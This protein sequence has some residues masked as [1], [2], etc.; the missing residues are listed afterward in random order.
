MKNG[1]AK[2]GKNM[3]SILA[4]VLIITQLISV[5]S[6]SATQP[7]K[8]TIIK[9]WLNAFIPKDIPRLTQPLPGN[10]PFSGKS[11][12]PGPVFTDI[13]LNSCF[14][15]DQ[16][17]FSSSPT[18]EQR[19]QSLAVIDMTTP[20]LTSQVNRLSPTVEINCRTGETICQKTGSN[21]GM[22]IQDVMRATNRDGS[23]TVRLRFVG[24]A[25]NP[26]F[27]HTPDVIVPDIDWDVAV[28]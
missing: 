22:T 1:Q 18:E 27:V 21:A 24:S 14:L 12:I 2:L 5:H 10:G 8:I 11:V 20:R 16:R 26:C 13:L 25:H 3:L 15:V 17:T 19:A 7:A 23:K 6:V 9:V 28:D 4:T